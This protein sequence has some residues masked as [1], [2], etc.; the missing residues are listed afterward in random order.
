VTSASCSNEGQPVRTCGAVIVVTQ[1]AVAGGEDRQAVSRST[2]RGLVDR[3][4]WQTRV[5]GTPGERRVLVHH[6]RT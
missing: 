6:G 3:G 2:A 4:R 1:Q 5:I